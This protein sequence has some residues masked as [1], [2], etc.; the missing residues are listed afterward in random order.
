MG[1][2]PGKQGRAGGRGRGINGYEQGHELISE[3]YVIHVRAVLVPGLVQGRA[4]QTQ[5]RGAVGAP[6]GTPPQCSHETQSSNGK[7]N[8]RIL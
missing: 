8:Q 6:N 4:Q 1:V 2:L 3:R 5:K 7:G